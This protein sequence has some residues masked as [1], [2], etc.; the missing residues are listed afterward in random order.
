MEL[1]IK[2]EAAL[3]HERGVK[4]AAMEVARNHVLDTLL[5]AEQMLERI[6]INCDPGHDCKHHM[7]LDSV[8]QGQVLVAWITDTLPEIVE[9]NYQQLVASVYDEDEQP[10]E[11]AVEIVRDVRYYT[12]QLLK[13]L[14]VKP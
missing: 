5:V 6:R 14:K 7:R 9:I 3:E 13:G 11:N 12:E 2:Q 4:K 1:S 8:K 10:L